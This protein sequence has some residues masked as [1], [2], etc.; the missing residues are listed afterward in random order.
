MNNSVADILSKLE[1][2]DVKSKNALENELVTIGG[3]AVPE[4]VRNLSVVRGTVRGVVAM[5]LIRIGAPSV[6]FLKKAAADNKDLAWVAQYLITEINA[7]A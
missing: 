4:L 5:T 7:A 3:Q 2:A 1:N 6:E